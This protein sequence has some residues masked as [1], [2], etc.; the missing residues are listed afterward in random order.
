MESF[1]QVLLV[2]CQVCPFRNSFVPH[3]SEF[4]AKDCYK[5][6]SCYE[7]VWR[8][9]SLM[10]PNLLSAPEGMDF[11]PVH[12]SFCAA[13]SVLS[14]LTCVH[15]YE[16]CGFVAWGNESGWRS[17]WKPGYKEEKSRGW[18]QEISWWQHVAAGW[19]LNVEQ[20]NWGH[21]LWTMT[22]TLQRL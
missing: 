7:S 11:P 1:G 5:V 3:L 14:W 10:Q 2:I 20:S 17:M 21:D 22:R 15:K 4:S 18:T 12:Q 9:R 19:T 8:N 13:V 16:I 6:H